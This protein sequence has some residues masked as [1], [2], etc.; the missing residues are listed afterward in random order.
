[1]VFELNRQNET[2]LY[3]QIREQI[4]RLIQAG[5]LEAADKL[6][7]SRSL[8]RA[9]GVNRHTVVQ[10]Y[11]DLEVAGRVRSGV[12]QGTFVAQFAR[13]DAAGL[14]PE[15]VGAP[16]ADFEGLWARMPR[17][18][19]QTGFSQLIPHRSHEEGVTSL[20]S[21]MPNKELFP[22]RE[23]RNCSYWAL[24]KHGAELLG[25]GAS[26]G[27]L[28]FLEHLPKYLMRHGLR[29]KPNE[30]IVTNGVQQG[31]EIVGKA[32]VN[33]GDVVL[34]EE[35]TYPGAISVF[36]GLGAE[37]LGIP[38]D[39]EGMK[40]DT[41]ERL[42]VWRKPKLIYTIPT[43]QNPTG[44]TLS[45]PRRRKL[46][47]L[48][49]AHRVPILEDQYANDLRLEGSVELPLAAMD[50]Q[51]WVIGVGSLS[52]VLFHGL[53]VG[54]LIARAE[55]MQRRL[56]ALKQASDLQTNYLVQGIILE[57]MQRG[58]LEKYVKKRLA[59]MRSR[60]DAM[61]QALQDYLPEPASWYEVEGGVCYWVTLPPPLRAD[62]VFLE[63]RRSG[64]VFAPKQIFA[65][66]PTANDAMR[67][68]FT[69]APEEKLRQAVRL[70][71]QVVKRL[72]ADGSPR[73]PDAAVR[74]RESEC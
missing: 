68:G 9:L 38:I 35:F 63:A 12:G 14:E 55:P 69:D 6:P 18:L 34:T 20:T 28:P 66:G 8:A 71:G 72:L 15:P 25:L 44:T 67:L 56:V 26:Q 33:P 52:K 21:C 37:V 2:P 43:F 40:V 10:A 60:R 17:E 3:V 65:V 1:M 58:F 53:R 36:R 5:T 62:E 48:A 74:S 54:W 46:L 51:G 57:F 11:Q 32:L 4:D 50:R 7:A 42:L 27:F 13:A 29:V 59:Q 16:E 47:E 73:R 30:L 41:L 49:A 70:I 22:M 23:F 24:Q 39:G 64:V 61:R 45:G 19:E 31:I